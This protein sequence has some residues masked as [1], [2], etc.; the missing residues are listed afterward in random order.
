[1]VF[2]REPKGDKSREGKGNREETKPVESCLGVTCKLEQS[3]I[4]VPCRA[5]NGRGKQ[6]LM[7]GAVLY[8]SRLQHP[9]DLGLIKVLLPFQR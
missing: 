4:L 1:M 2:P 9:W 8:C 3:Q 5:S 7:F 6:Q